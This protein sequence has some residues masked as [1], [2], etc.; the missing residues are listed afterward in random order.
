MAPGSRRIEAFVGI[1]A[2]QHLA[3]AERALVSELTSTLKVQ[4]SDIVPRIEKLLE[5]LQDAEKSLAKFQQQAMLGA[6]EEIAAA[7]ADASGISVVAHHAAE[8][9]SSDDARTLVADVRQRLGDGSPT[10][11]AIAG[12]ADGKPFIVIGTN[13][14][15]RDA[16][17]KAGEL[18]KAASTIMGGGG[19]GKPDLAQGGG[20]DASKLS[21]ALDA[22][23]DAVKNR[24]LTWRP[25]LRPRLRS[26]SSPVSASV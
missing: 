24:G 12:A 21:A 11:V 10:V 19:G 18:V 17:V 8:A 16:G 23:V 22:V 14:G 1:E 2:F 6:S 13:Q 3:A 7:A 4:P 20:Q 15:A 9:G 25:M 26:T 5:R